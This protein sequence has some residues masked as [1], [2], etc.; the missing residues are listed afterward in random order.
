MAKVGVKSLVK[1]SIQAAK[2]AFQ[3]T[4]EKVFKSGFKNGMKNLGKILFKTFI[5]DIDD[6]TSGK[7]EKEYLI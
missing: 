7:M 5:F 6:F 3:E 2:F 1:G 4:V